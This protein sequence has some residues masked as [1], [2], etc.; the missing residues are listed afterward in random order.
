M[1]VEIKTNDFGKIGHALGVVEGIAYSLETGTYAQDLVGAAGNYAADKI[2][3]QIDAMALAPNSNLQHVYEWRAVGLKA[4]RL[5]NVYPKGNGKSRVVTF[6]F[7]A[8][9]TPVP[10]LRER[11][12]EGKL[13]VDINDPV[14]K[15]GKRSGNKVNL[16]G[17]FVFH[18]KAQYMEYGGS[19]TVSSKKGK[20]IFVPFK[21]EMNGR[22][23]AFVPSTK[24][25]FANVKFRGSFH[26]AFKIASI[27]TGAKVGKEIERLVEEDVEKTTL[28]MGKTGQKTINLGFS[29]GQDYARNRMKLA[30]NMADANLK[31]M[32]GKS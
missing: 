22:K 10:T 5:F 4:G 11:I 2:G 32:G 13:A 9:K 1:T 24:I 3:E 25:D 18:Q 31:R 20:K 27:H 15:P 6:H 7:T 19:V 23:F 21:H 30:G 26:L 8:S 12:N 17:R 14:F 16:D 28:R 29:E